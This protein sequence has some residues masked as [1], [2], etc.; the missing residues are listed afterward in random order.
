MT[1]KALHR[2]PLIEDSLN[3]ARRAPSLWEL[4]GAFSIISLTGFGGGQKA[5]IRREVVTRR[6]WLTE[7][8]FLEGLELSELLPGPNILN[9]T[10]FIGQR[11]RGVSGALLSLIA[12]ALP[13]FLIVLA[14]GMFYFSRFNT[15]LVHAALK[16][17]A[18]AAVGLTLANALGEDGSAKSMIITMLPRY[19]GTV[20]D[21]YTYR[22]S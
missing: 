21:A 11:L 6:K 19:R 10:V 3:A 20:G 17:A 1:A 18:A 8:E 9:L 5:Q 4:I 16:G 12:G 13:A 2:R 14:A 15:P 7:Q 22:P